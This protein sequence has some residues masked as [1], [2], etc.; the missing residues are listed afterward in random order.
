MPRDGQTCH[1]QRIDDRGDDQVRHS[2]TG[3][4]S[5]PDVGQV[6]HGHRCDD[7]QVAMT[8]RLPRVPTTA[9]TPST[10]T[11]NAATTGFRLYNDPSWS[12]ADSELFISISSVS[13]KSIVSN[14][15]LRLL[16]LNISTYEPPR[17]YSTLACLTGSSLTQYVTDAI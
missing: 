14:F 1:S 7:D 12:A 3:D 6:L 15:A 9:A 17:T 8:T 13:G 5:P 2:E 16:A 11:Y 4:K 10:P